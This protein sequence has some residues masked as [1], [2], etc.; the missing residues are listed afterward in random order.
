MAAAV[1]ANSLAN[2]FALDDL[3]L[4]R[5]NPEIRRLSGA[6]LAA[7]R[8]YWPQGE[9]SGLYRPLV[10]A[11]YAL[12]YAVTG[13]GPAGFHAVN[14]LLH[15]AASVLAW[16]ALRRVGVHYGT[17]LGGALL[18]AVHPVH[19]EAV[20][21]VVG[22][23]EILAAIGVLSAWLLHR[24]DRLV[25]AAACYLAALLSKETALLAPLLFVL[26]DRLRGERPGTR[27]PKYA[28][29]AAALLVALGLR[30][31]VLGGWRGAEDV[32]FLDNPTA[33]G[34]APARIATALWVQARY[35][36][37]WLWPRPL[38]SDYSYD[39]VPS[40]ASPGDVRL[41]IGLA[42]ATAAGIALWRGVRRTPPLA[43]GAAT[44]ILFA[45]PSSNLVFPA[46]T[47]MAERLTY[48]PSLGAALLTA[49]AVAGARAAKRAVVAALA[50]A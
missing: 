42:L 41:W 28:P 10:I 35:A 30:L 49:H 48:L 31:V 36:G 5:D 24:R 20:A 43:L 13:A 37:L 25:A 47:L 29:Y 9:G 22:R 17:A 19:A 14:V 45:L 15:A 4:V 33:F 16:F 32:A 50:L 23:A 8:P 1:Y 39:A 21:N 12:N 26:D 44:W 40:V 2:G 46:G 34:P 3:P 27:W 38:S 11:S 6:T 7:A 18:F